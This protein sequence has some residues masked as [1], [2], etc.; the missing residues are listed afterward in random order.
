MSKI[1][2]VL[3]VICFAIYG[4]VCFQSIF[5]GKDCDN[6]FTLSDYHNQIGSMNHYP[7]FKV[8]AYKMVCVAHIA[9]FLYILC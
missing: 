5:S 3:S 9:M 7:L 6:I 2:S 4:I 1:K 8:S